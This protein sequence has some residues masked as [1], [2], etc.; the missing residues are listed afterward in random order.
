MGTVSATHT[1]QLSPGYL[2]KPLPAVLLTEQP[3]D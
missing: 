1:K 3:A 2:L